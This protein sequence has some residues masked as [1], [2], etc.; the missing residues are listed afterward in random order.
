MGK[1]VQRAILR[2]V[3]KVVGLFRAGFRTKLARYTGS[4]ITTRI[5]GGN[6]KWLDN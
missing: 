5:L 1:T 4:T 6:S 3:R 2:G